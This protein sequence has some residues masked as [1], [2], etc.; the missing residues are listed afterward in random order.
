MIYLQNMDLI[1]QES[2][3]PLMLFYKIKGTQYMSDKIKLFDLDNH[4]K[5]KVK[6]MVTLRYH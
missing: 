3:D 6:V 4:Q 2:N 1:L 5:T